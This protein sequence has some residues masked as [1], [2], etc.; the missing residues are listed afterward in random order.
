MAT[1]TWPQK[2]INKSM[3]QTDKASNTSSQT[4]SKKMTHDCARTVT[5]C[6]CNEDNE[7]FTQTSE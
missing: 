7:D 1:D 5:L 2:E 6:L 3:S 4:S